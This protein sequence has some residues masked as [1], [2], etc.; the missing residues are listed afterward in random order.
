[1]VKVITDSTA[2]VPTEIALEM[3]ITVVPCYVVFDSDT[4][5]DGV[6]LAKHQFYKKLTSNLGIPTTAAPPPSA[7]EAVYRRVSKETDEIVSIHLA[8][9]LS[10]MYSSAAAGA[11]GFPEARVEVIDSEQVSM[12]YGWMA[13]AAAEAAQRGASLGEIVAL[14]TGMRDR[15]RL[16]AILDTVEFLHRGGR[17]NWVQAMLGTLLRIKPIIQVHCSEVKLL[18]RSRTWK[19]SLKR[20]AD[21][22]Q[23]FGPLERAMILHTNAPDRA[24]LVASQ[25]RA[26]I[27]QWDPI[28]GQAGVTIAAHAGPG[29]VGIACVTAIQ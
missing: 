14:V 13:I 21:M 24:A 4:Y 17:V 9:G 28:I 2:D 5:R 3:G 18:E 16:L 15:S 27:P 1:M 19:R 8:A 22:L 6:E 20:L 23:E 11:R 25:L 10:A 26:V 29:A 7:Y 12:G